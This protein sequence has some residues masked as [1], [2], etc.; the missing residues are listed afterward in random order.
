MKFLVAFAVLA[1]TASSFAQV[2]HRRTAPRDRGGREVTRVVVNERAET[3]VR[4]R[5]LE[6]A[7]SALQAQVYDLQDEPDYVTKTVC[8]MTLPYGLG[9]HVGKAFSKIEAEAQA[10]NK[11]LN[12]QVEDARL[13]CN[14]TQQI[15]Q[16][17]LELV[18]NN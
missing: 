14:R 3:I 17:I 2:V 5:N 12:S 8:T 4:L 1:I 18:P 6:M 11:C 16:E 13:F 7:V 10:S 15:C 9:V